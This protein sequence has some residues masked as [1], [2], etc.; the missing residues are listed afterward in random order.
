MELT[1]FSPRP[2]NQTQEVFLSVYLATFNAQLAAMRAGITVEEAYDL[3]K[4]S[5]FRAAMDAQYAKVFG[6]PKI[7]ANWVLR[8][9]VENHFIARQTGNLAA[10]NAALNL[11]AKHA[12]VDAFS[13]V[14]IEAVGDREK[15]DRILAAR[16]RKDVDFT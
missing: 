15:I 5:S 13:A 6:T 2:L 14:K 4:D 1:T 12:L 9:L 11:I 10:S 8:E 16:K 7:D 3:L